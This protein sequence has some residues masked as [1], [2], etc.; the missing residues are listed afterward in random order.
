MLKIVRSSHQF[1][2]RVFRLVSC[3]EK[4]YTVELPLYSIS[5]L[6]CIAPDF[7]GPRTERYSI[8]SDPDPAN[9]TC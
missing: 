4:V 7:L 3:Y 5:T 9:I 8:D 6:Y 2:F 1:Y